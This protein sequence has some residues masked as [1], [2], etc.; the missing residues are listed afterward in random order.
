MRRIHENIMY[1]ELKDLQ[2]V[3]VRVEMQGSSYPHCWIF[4]SEAT[5]LSVSK[6]KRLVGFLN[7]FIKDAQQQK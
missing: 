5:K 1:G 6:A 2:H 4:S 3:H 7:A